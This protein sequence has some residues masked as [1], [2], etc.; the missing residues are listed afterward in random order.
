MLVAL[1]DTGA[2]TSLIT[3]KA[4]ERIRLIV[5]GA[6]IELAGLNGAASTVG[7]AFIGLRVSG[8][9]I[10]RQVRVIVVEALPEGQDMLLGCADLKAF[11]IIHKEFPKPYRGSRNK[12][13]GPLN[14]RRYRQ[15][16]G[17]NDGLQRMENA[18]VALEV[19]SEPLTIN[20]TLF[21]P[22]KDDNVEDIP[23]LDD[24]PDVIEDA[25]Y[26]HRSVFANDLS[27]Q[28]RPTSLPSQRG[29][30]VTTKVSEGAV[31]APPP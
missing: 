28:V 3:R 17:E 1:A 25:L 20:Q 12:L 6:N 2:S 5:R 14:A 4:S 24:M 11:D 31:D 13:E 16:G 18:F 27:D 10:K 21:R 22:H 19:D 23:G 15:G 29:R 8:V 26:R 9:D 30:G 7:E